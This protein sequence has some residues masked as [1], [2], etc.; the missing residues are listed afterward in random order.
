MG[1]QRVRH[2]RATK[3]KHV[4]GPDDIIGHKSQLFK[5]DRNYVKDFFDL[6]GMDL[7][8]RRKDRDH[9]LKDIDY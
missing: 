5:G 8:I 9:G 1:S 3:H 4:S 6:S 7:Q 2:D